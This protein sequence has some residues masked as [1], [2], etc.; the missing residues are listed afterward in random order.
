ML[1]RTIA[2]MG[3]L[4]VWRDGVD[5]RGVSR[6]GQLSTLAPRRLN[7]P[8]QQFVDPTDT[9]EGLNGIQRI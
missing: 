9:F 3:R 4:V 2:G 8:V 6:K 7:D 1:D 5:I